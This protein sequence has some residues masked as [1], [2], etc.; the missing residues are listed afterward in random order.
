MILYVTGYSVSL[1]AIEIQI[2]KHESVKSAVCHVVGDD[3]VHKQLVAYIVPE[4]ECKLDALQLRA[5]LRKRL[6]PYM[7]PN[8]LM[9]ID[10]IPLNK[11]SGKTDYHQ[12]TVNI[13]LR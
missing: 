6:P 3:L 10:K 7:I 9:K 1:L 4:S 2:A 13:F 8:Y 12:V 11:V 5:Y